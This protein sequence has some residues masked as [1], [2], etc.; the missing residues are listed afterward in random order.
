MTERRRGFTLMELMVVVTIIGILAGLAMPSVFASLREMRASSARA[1]VVR[2]LNLGRAAARGTGKAHLLEFNAAAAQTRGQLAAYRSN[3]SSC[4]NTDWP[5]ILARSNNCATFATA[6]PAD[7]DCIARTAF[8]N[9]FEVT[10]V[11]AIQLTEATHNLLYLCYEPGGRSFWSNQASAA[12]L[13][14]A[15]PAASNGA[16]VFTLTTQRGGVG[17]PTVGVPRQILQPFGST[18]R[19]RR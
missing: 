19:V 11:Y 2:I 12:S 5:T 6:S 9:L 7:D 10:N 13:Q 4:A 3:G 15:P 17:G 18:A 14:P 1:D 8:P 16:F